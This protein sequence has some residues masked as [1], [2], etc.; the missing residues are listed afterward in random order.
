MLKYVPTKYS[1]H[2]LWNS[3]N[4]PH[5]IILDFSIFENGFAY[6]NRFQDIFG[7]EQSPRLFT[8]RTRFLG[9]F[10]KRFFKACRIFVYFLASHDILF[11]YVNADFSNKTILRN[12]SSMKFFLCY[13]LYSPNPDGEKAQSRSSKTY[14]G[15]FN[16]NFFIDRF[17]LLSHYISYWKIILNRRVKLCFYL[18]NISNKLKLTPLIN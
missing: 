2:T 6:K 1:T 14:I 12:F 17:E 5:C 10:K 4:F 16:F 15:C 18:E 13:Y 3:V 11:W 7:V 8:R 9:H